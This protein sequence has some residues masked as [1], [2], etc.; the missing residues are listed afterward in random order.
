MSVTAEAVFLL[1]AAGLLW[2]IVMALVA[3]RRAL[4]G[5]HSRKDAAAVAAEFRVE[6][7]EGRHARTEPRLMTDE[8]IDAGLAELLARGR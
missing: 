1:S 5:G 2:I 7:R 3:A 8:E 6:E 4:G